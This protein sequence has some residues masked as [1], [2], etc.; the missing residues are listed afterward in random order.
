MTENDIRGNIL[1]VVESYKKINTTNGKEKHSHEI[2][3][4][5]AIVA[6][7]TQVLVD[8]N[9]IANALEHLATK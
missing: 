3:C 5:A 7:V 9:R 6:L 1:C 4:E 2:V 8:L